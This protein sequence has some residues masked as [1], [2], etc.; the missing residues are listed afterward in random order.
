MET[1]PLSGTV[2]PEQAGVE[3]TR[4]VAGARAELE[5]AALR[6]SW[7]REEFEVV[8]T[9]EPIPRSGLSIM[10]RVAV[11]ILKKEGV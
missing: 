2:S 5:S 8:T 7:P 11:R 10:Y 6:A 1:I 3:I 9:I 4:L